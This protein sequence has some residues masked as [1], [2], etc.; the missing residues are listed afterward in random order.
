MTV[1]LRKTHPL[2]PI[3]VGGCSDNSHTASDHVHCPGRERSREARPQ[4]RD[5]IS[6]LRTVSSDIP[7]AASLSMS[8][9]FASR[10][11][12]RRSAI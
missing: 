12:T 8:V 1:R 10:C 3:E 6:S 7:A 9:L 11:R 2:V 4:A 5:A